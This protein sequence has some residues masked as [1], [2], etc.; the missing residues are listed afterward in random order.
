MNPKYPIFI[1]SKGRVESRLTSKALDAI[2]VPYQCVVEP[3]EF[4]DY[5]AVLSR[6]KLIVLPFSDKGLVATRNWIWDRAV[7]QGLRYFW[8]IDDNIRG[9][10][11]WNKNLKVPVAD[12]A[13]LR[14]AEDFSE[15]YNNV[16][17]SGLNYRMFE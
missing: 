9:F 1:P 12:G 14:A 10:Y 6:E 4:D 15:R 5:A 3:Q 8:T 11:R 16:A 17:I 7:E 2:G 13:I